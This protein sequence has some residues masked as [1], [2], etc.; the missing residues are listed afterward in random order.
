MIVWCQHGEQKHQQ[1]RELSAV[2]TSLLLVGS[3]CFICVSLHYFGQ[4]LIPVGIQV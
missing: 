4:L 1:Q 2:E 3:Q